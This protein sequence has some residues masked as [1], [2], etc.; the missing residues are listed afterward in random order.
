MFEMADTLQ[1]PP[2]DSVSE[3][4]MFDYLESLDEFKAKGNRMKSAFSSTHR[5][6]KKKRL[7][8]STN[9][10][11]ELEHKKETPKTRKLSERELEGLITGL[12]N[13]Q[14]TDT[15][16]AILRLHLL[17]LAR[18]SEI[19]KMGISELDLAGGVWILPAERSKNG[20]EFLI[21]LSPRAV[22]ELVPFILNRFSGYVFQGVSGKP[23]QL[24]N[25]RQAMQRI[26]ESK[27]IPSATPHDL[28]RTSAN[29]INSSGVVNEDIAK[30]LNHSTR[31]ITS[32]VYVQGGLYDH[33]NLKKNILNQWAETLTG[34]GL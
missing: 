32:D 12:N 19:C 23:V 4:V 31:S 33:A 1:D 30:L 10:T 8:T 6:L 24:W 14:V 34:Y 13:S 22:Q 7:I 18:P 29:L 16:K 20:K 17:T 28:R 2:M 25:T 27:K 5:W 3:H 26:L 9:P 11:L 15:H 21:P